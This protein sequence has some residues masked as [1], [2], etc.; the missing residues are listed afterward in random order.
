M[1]KAIP[2]IAFDALAGLIVG[3]ATFALAGYLPLWYGWSLGFLVF[4]AAANVLYGCYS[5][6][7]WFRCKGSQKI[8]RTMV[9]FLIIA[10]GLWSVHCVFQIW[11][12]FEAATFFGL[13]HIGLEAL[14]VGGLA[15]V[16]ARVILP[17]AE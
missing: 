9:L 2:L 14:F 6:T 4:M 13:A 3:L 12:L 1:Q 5:A 10:N 17:V 8:S 16:E 7:L 11:R 15:L